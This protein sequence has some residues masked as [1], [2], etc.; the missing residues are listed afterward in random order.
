MSWARLGSGLTV[1]QQQANRVQLRQQ[2][3]NVLP[4]AIGRPVR[5]YIVLLAYRAYDLVYSR[6]DAQEFQSIRAIQFAEPPPIRAIAP[7]LPGSPP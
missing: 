6:P 4:H 1:R 3:P 7:N 5:R 2:R